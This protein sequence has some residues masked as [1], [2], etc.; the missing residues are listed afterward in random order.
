MSNII[1]RHDK[2]SK[3]DFSYGDFVR[4]CYYHDREHKIA[5]AK[6][7]FQFCKGAKANA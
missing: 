6:K 7:S 3:S 2:I 1:E 4:R 5:Q